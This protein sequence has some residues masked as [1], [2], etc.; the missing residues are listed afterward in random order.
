MRVVRADEQTFLDHADLARE[1]SA[2]AR[3]AGTLIRMAPPATN[4]FHVKV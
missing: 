1:E 4:R 3:H 2:S